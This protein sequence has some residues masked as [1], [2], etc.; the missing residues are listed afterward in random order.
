MV[1]AVFTAFIWLVGTVLVIQG[2][3]W[4]GCKLLTWGDITEEQ[5]WA[6]E[7][8]AFTPTRPNLLE[9]IRFN[10]KHRHPISR[11]RRKLF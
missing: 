4:L 3:I 8:G 7:H 5:M 9:R 10:R 1:D 6:A 11:K 2:A